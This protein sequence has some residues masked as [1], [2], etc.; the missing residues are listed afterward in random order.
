M[1]PATLLKHLGLNL[2]P[3]LTWKP[4]LKEIQAKTSTRVGALASLGASTWGTELVHLRRVYR[5]CVLPQFLYCCSTWF[6]IGAARGLKT[7][8]REALTVLESVQYRAGRLITG[9][10]R[11]RSKPAIDIEAFLPPVKYSLMQAIGDSLLRIQSTPLFDR[12]LD[13]RN[14]GST[15]R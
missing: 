1:Q 10:F 15:Q 4:Q 3:Q 5:A 2:D 9:A 8:E 6:P 7:L 12:I 13:I 14:S 11:C